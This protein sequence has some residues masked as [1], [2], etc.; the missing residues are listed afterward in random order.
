MTLKPI[1]LASPDAARRTIAAWP[2]GLA[3]LVAV[4]LMLLVWGWTRGSDARVIAGLPAE[5][6]ARLFQLTRSK[7]EALCAEPALEDRCHEEV[8][9]LSEFPECSGG[10]RDF[11]ARHRS[12]G[13]R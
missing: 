10:C 7:A 6:R 9:L 11:V 8:G 13:S 1:R 2:V 3:L 12:H 5:E 4:V